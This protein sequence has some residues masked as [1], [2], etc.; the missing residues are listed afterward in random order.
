MYSVAK[1]ST[2]PRLRP[3]NTEHAEARRHGEWSWGWLTHDFIFP[4]LVHV[5]E[6]RAPVCHCVQSTVYNLV[7]YNPF[8]RHAPGGGAG[9]LCATSPH[10]SV[11]SCLCASVLTGR[12]PTALHAQGW[13]NHRSRRSAPLPLCR[14]VQPAV[15]NLVVYNPFRRHAPGAARVHCAPP[16][17]DSV[18][19]CLCASVLTGRRPTAPYV[20]GWTNHRSRRNATLPPCRR[21]R[22]HRN[23][24]VYNPFGR[25][26]PRAARVH[27][28]PPLVPL[29]NP[30]QLVGG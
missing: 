5:R 27:C 18:P 1:N 26:A 29:C 13:T 6:G 22:P 4:H 19:S 2:L 24:I 28:A 12:R 3:V 15:Y 7:V 25:H 20:R 14:H 11:P 30:C 21:V 23:P 9:T 8:G 16:P 10:D 17:H